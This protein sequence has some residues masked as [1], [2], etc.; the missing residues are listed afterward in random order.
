MI[1][2]N[3]LRIKKLLKEKDMIIDDLKDIFILRSHD[4]EMRLNSILHNSFVK[5]KYLDT[6]VYEIARELNVCVD[7]LYGWIDEPMKFISQDTNSNNKQLEIIRLIDKYCIEQ[8]IERKNTNILAYESNIDRE[9]F[10]Y[11]YSGNKDWSY[12]ITTSYEIISKLAIR[13]NFNFYTVMVFLLDGESN[14]EREQICISLGRK[15]ENEYGIK[16]I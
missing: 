16:T 6:F 12:T 10:E 11:L 15:F 2:I 4:T 5:D 14:D 9:I 13:F 8:G 3:C 7:Y 1:T